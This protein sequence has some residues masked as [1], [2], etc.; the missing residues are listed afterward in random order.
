M[1]ERK[2]IK[3]TVKD[4]ERGTRLDRVICEQAGIGKRA[5]QRLVTGRKVKING[6][7]VWL[8]SWKVHNGDRIE[9]AQAVEQAPVAKTQPATKSERESSRN[10]SEL[11]CF[12]KSWLIRDAREMLAL[13][14]P[15]GMLTH[16]IRKGQGGD[17]FSLALEKFGPISLYNRLDR[18][19]S[20]VVLFTRQGPVNRYLDQVFKQ[21]LAQKTYLALVLPKSELPASGRV[22][23]PIGFDPKRNKCMRVDGRHSRPAV[24]DYEVLGSANG[25][26]LVKLSPHSG[27]THQL[28]LHMLELNAP[29][30][31]DKLYGGP[32]LRAARLMLHA[33]SL[34]L[35]EADG[36]PA[37]SF[38]APVPEDF[39]RVLPEALRELAQHLQP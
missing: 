7:L 32:G 28:R 30:I 14:K 37:R 20:G 36:F 21:H 3:L 26:S 24:T 27:R 35:P 39:L 1:T 16:A 18:D 5:V 22:D 6:K 25:A 4:L 38:T 12:D 15:A 34:S 23:A 9:V 2:S 19:T 11:P 13:N 8:C 17:L 33:L 29:I 10:F 31:G